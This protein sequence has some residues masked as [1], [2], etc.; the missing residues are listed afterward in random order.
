MTPAAMQL[1]LLLAL[2]ANR[3]G[4]SYYGDRRIQQTLNLSSSKLARARQELI[5]LDLIAFDGE[6]YQLLAL[7][8]RHMPLRASRDQQAADSS[9]NPSPQE[10]PATPTSENPADHPQPQFHPIPEEAREIL[11]RAFGPDFV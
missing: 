6:T 10:Q 5:I 1:Y 11:R 7:P 9:A 4:M 2:A 3:Q 8:D